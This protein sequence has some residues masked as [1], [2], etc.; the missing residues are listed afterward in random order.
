[1]SSE[2][3]PE[4]ASHSVMPERASRSLTLSLTVGFA[5]AIGLR[6]AIGLPDVSASTGAGLAFALA[7]YGLAALSRPRLNASPKALSIGVVVG[8]LLCAPAV[9]ARI[10]F[11]D[12]HRPEGSFLTWS[13][14]VSVVAVAEEVFLR[15]ALRDAITAWRGANTAVV[16]GAVLFA[17]LHLPLYGWGS[18]P[19]DLGVGLILGYLRE[20]TGSVAAPAGA[21]V[22]AD[23]IAWWLR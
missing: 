8:A 6:I 17:A 14:I 1:M 19:L 22:T 11:T 10:A 23:L 3:E 4:T 15:G 12:S 20:R 13:L 2:P 5:A 16:V 7:L 18:V 21:H 9:L